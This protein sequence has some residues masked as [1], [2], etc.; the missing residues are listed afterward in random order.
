MIGKLKGLVDFVTEDHVIIDVNGVGYVVFASAH[1]LRQLPS[2]GEAVAVIIETHVREDHIHLY[3]F[4]DVAERDMFRK[5]L[6]VKG[7]GTKMALA[8]LSVLTPSQ[9]I[10]AVVA[11]DKS[12]FKP[13]SGVGPKLATRIVTELKDAF[14]ALEFDMGIT[15]VTGS[16]SSSSVQAMKQEVSEIADAISAL[17]NLGYSRDKAYKV[18]TRVVERE[19]ELSVSELIRQG[20]KELSA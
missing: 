10:Q 11:Q 13:V 4:A 8:I 3:G 14:G 12:A 9:F 5:V 7:V 2:V 16:A 6:Q 1:T 19:G 17:V 18:I 20:L 15:Q